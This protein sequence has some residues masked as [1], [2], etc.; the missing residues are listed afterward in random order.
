[1]IVVGDVHGMIRTLEALIKKF[2]D[3]NEPIVFVGDLIDRGPNSKEVVEFVRGNGYQT[4]LGNHEWM[5]RSALDKTFKSP[6]WAPQSWL[7]NGGKATIE[8]FGL[9]PKTCT[10]EQFPDYLVPWIASLPLY[11]KFPNAMGTKDVIVSHAGWSGRYTLRTVADGIA[12]D[13]DGILWYRGV[14]QKRRNT[15][16]VFGHTPDRPATL[17]DYYA[18]IDTG[19]W[20]TLTALRLPQYELYQQENVNDKITGRGF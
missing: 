20:D 6:W 17:E 11:L 4:V 16:F 10:P 14:P 15:F 5:C 18:R 9:D 7:G 8:S 3:P 2:P 19:A 1:M 13:L 12:D